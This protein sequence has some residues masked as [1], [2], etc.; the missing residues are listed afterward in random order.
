LRELEHEEQ[1]AFITWVRYAYPKLM[2]FSIPNGGKRSKAVA[3]KMKAEG[4]ISG[5]PDI[6]VAK[7]SNGYPALFIEMKSAKGRMSDTQK[8]IKIRLEAEGYKV[9]VCYSFDEARQVLN[10]YLNCDRAGKN[11]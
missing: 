11:K 9:E 5:I 3:G 4:V 10:N 2:L 8:D 6:L 1:K 7:Q